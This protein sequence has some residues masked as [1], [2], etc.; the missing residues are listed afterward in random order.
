[1]SKYQITIAAA[2]LAE[3]YSSAADFAASGGVTVQM[4]DS[5]ADDENGPINT[6]APIFDSGAD[7]DAGPVNTAAPI[8]DSAWTPWDDRIHSGTKGTNADGTWKRRRNTPDATFA[9]VMTELKARGVAPAATPTPAAPPAMQAAVNALMPGPAVP[10]AP[11]YIPGTPPTMASEPQPATTLAPMSTPL[12]MAAPA[13]PSGIMS[14]AE[15]MPK[16]NAAMQAGRF[17]LE[18]LNT[19]YLPQWGL[20]N[21]G[22]L[23]QDP[24]TTFKFFEW[25]KA[26]GLVD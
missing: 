8:F 5:G 26:S 24:A 4:I 25:L 7:D 18:T 1:M 11:P 10:P 19:V 17:S 13:A 16:L 23:S 3:L 6:A 2:T 9:A 22:Q 21:V 14:F 12:N 20:A 15:F